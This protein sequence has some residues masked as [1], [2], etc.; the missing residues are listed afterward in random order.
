M[1]KYRIIPK[2]I[3]YGREARYNIKNKIGLPLSSEEISF[4]NFKIQTIYN[5]NF[6]LKTYSISDLENWKNKYLDHDSI[7]SMLKDISEKPKSFMNM[8]NKNF[9]IFGIL[10]MTPDSFSNN[11]KNIPSLNQ[12][13][14]K[15]VKMCEE[16]ADII[17]VG[18]E[19]SR[20]GSKPINPIEEQRRIIP[21]IYKLSKM[22]ITVSCDTRN[23]N[24]M[25]KAIEAGA[26][27]I[28]DIS[29]LNDK[30]SANIIS[31]NKVGVVLMHMLG[32][33]SNMQTKPK[34]KNV[35]I[36]IINYLEEK[37][38][39]AINQGIKENKILIDPGIGFGKNDYH[40]IKIFKNLSM[41]HCINSNIMIGASRKSL[42]GRLTNTSIEQ[43]LPSS[44]ALAISAI[45]KGVKFYRV[46]EVKETVQAL[47]MWNKINY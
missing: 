6:D 41:L 16:G 21:I 13:V 8:K 5:Q 11:S 15:A 24:T 3:A 4:N 45:E 40:N 35:S 20:P 1:H 38:K 36:E 37:K 46:H 17:D 47:T 12:A 34:Y 33:P 10:N 9:Y 29:S 26:K 39:Y 2:N 19:S 7:H 43:R 25:E 28:N 32:K 30:N 14:K 27:I 42:I 18:G 31:K 22:N 23:S 44:I